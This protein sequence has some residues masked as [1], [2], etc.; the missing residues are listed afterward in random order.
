MG[1]RLEPP[2]TLGDGQEIAEVFL[3]T[4]G[5]VC[6]GRLIMRAWAD[7]ALMIFPSANCTR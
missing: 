6:C 1:E 4:Q 7:D 2:E 5:S 3:L